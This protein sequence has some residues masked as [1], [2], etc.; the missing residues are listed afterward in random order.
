MKEPPTAPIGG[1]SHSALASALN[2]IV[3]QPEADLEPLPPAGEK[4][5]ECAGN[6]TSDASDSPS[7][8]TPAT[9]LQKQSSV[10]ALQTDLHDNVP[11]LEAPTTLQQPRCTDVVVYQEP[12]PCICSAI[13]RTDLE[14]VAEPGVPPLQGES[15]TPP[16]SWHDLILLLPPALQRDLNRHAICCTRA[17]VYARNLA[18]DRMHAPPSQHRPQASAPQ[19]ARFMPCPCFPPR[20]IPCACVA[21]D[22]RYTQTSG[23]RARSHAPHPHCNYL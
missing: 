12:P 3:S 8:I 13:V 16:P 7:T 10:T 9:S 17:V 15:F 1:I 5:G 23:A 19:E 4:N 21:A 6:P 18:L 14:L 20:A 2:L 11:K 22:H